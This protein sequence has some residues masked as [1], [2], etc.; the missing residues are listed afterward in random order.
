MLSRLATAARVSRPMAWA[1]ARQSSSI[2]VGEP[3]FNESVGLYFE[4]VKRFRNESHSGLFVFCLKLKAPSRYVTL[5]A[6]L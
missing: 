3:T 1:L 6:L 2:A 5:P 4:E